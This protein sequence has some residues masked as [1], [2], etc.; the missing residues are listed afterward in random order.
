MQQ[1][2]DRERLVAIE[3]ILN[4]LTETLKA[5]TQEL[6]DHI[7]DETMDFSDLKEK[8]AIHLNDSEEM[9]AELAILKKDV[10]FLKSDRIRVMGWIAGVVFVAGVMWMLFSSWVDHST[11]GLFK[12]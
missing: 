5:H 1:R 7:H 11:A 3:T 2:T 10:S 6:R 9:M 12:K 4:H 8:L